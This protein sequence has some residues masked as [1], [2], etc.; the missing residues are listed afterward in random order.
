VDIARKTHKGLDDTENR[1]R[2]AIFKVDIKGRLDGCSGARL[3]G[4]MVGIRG[5]SRR[6]TR[7]RSTK[8]LTLE[9][10]F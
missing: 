2:R 9:S 8:A 3:V 6:R 4:N 7:R 10:L 1:A 5:Y